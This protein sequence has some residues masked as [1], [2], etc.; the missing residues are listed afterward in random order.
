MLNALNQNA[1]IG[2]ESLKQNEFFQSS[3][4]SPNTFLNQH[5]HVKAVPTDKKKVKFMPEKKFKAL[6]FKVQ[7]NITVTKEDRETYKE[8]CVLR[9]LK[10]FLG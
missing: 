3:Q 5:Q 8:Q 9:K 1:R 2:S 4:K 6:R 7:L 10:R